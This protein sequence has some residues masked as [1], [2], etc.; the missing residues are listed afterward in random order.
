MENNQLNKTI[1][2]IFND[3]Y[4][5]PL[6]QRS[7][8]WG[9]DEILQL[10]QDIYDAY[11]QKVENYYIGTLVVLKRHDGR[12]E[13]IDG[14]QRLTVL[15]LLTKILGINSELRLS[16][17][18]RPKVEN[19]LREFYKDPNYKS[20]EAQTYNLSNAVNCIKDS[21]VL[22]SNGEIE[23]IDGIKEDLG[24]FLSNNVILF[25]VEIPEDTDVATY[26]EIMNNRGEQLQKHEIFKARLMEKLN[27][28]YHDEFNLIWTACSNID[29]HI[30]Q[31]FST[32]KRI[33]YFGRNYDEYKFE[34]FVDFKGKD[35]ISKNK[36]NGLNIRSILRN[37][38]T[39]V[40]NNTT[41]ETPD[42]YNSIIDFP[43]FL[44][45]V[46]KLYMH[47]HWRNEEQNIPLDEKYLIGKAK[48]DKA[49][50][51]IDPEKFINLLFKC[52]VLFD[53]YIIKT[54]SNELKDEFKWSL[55]YSKFDNIS[56]CKEYNTY[57]NA[58]NIIKA[59][60]MLQVTFR[61]RIYKNWLYDTLKF[62]YSE[63]KGDNIEA[64]CLLKHLDRWMKNYYK[65]LGKFNEFNNL[66]TNT[67]HF[68]LNFIDYLYWRKAKSNQDQINQI[69]IKDFS[70]KY[71]NSVE[72]HLS[73]NKATEKNKGTKPDW[74]DQIGNLFLISKNAN[75][76]LSDRDVKEKVGS[77]KDS[78]MG[79]SRQIIY[80]KT[81]NNNYN[82]GEEEINKQTTEVLAL[83]EEIDN[84][85]GN[86]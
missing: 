3:S 30:Q 59:Q 24:E 71:W 68:I 45:H 20:S 61:Q 67:P 19:F 23:T 18:S 77:Y 5:I 43:N 53:R 41:K 66:G 80:H 83:L 69:E 2:Q 36:S 85:L 50:N 22:K 76:R 13:V 86:S 44:M 58:F 31:C 28:K 55:K 10:I 64:T 49:F 39:S 12:Y 25:K 84:I 81:E 60:S 51:R 63:Y 14:Q 54:E 21:R 70:F 33:L 38:I 1:K 65:E 82:W 7:F 79:P 78:N 4:V 62:L 47:N 52:R 6:Y 73:V 57:E 48:Q 34:G 27:P 42:K 74:I 40:K 46:L 35:E 11:K 17:D 9:D 29:T 8:A 75:S 32:E 26:F 37:D 16:Y 72:H 15:S 56:A